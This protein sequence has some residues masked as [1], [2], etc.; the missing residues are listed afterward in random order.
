MT[1]ASEPQQPSVARSRLPDPH[2]TQSCG[3]LLC[4]GFRIRIAFAYE[5]TKW[6]PL[7]LL[8]QSPSA[9]LAAK[10]HTVD[11]WGSV[12]TTRM[13][14][15]RT[16]KRRERG[17]EGDSLA[18]IQPRRRPGPLEGGT[19]LARGRERNRKGVGAAAAGGTG[20]DSCGAGSLPRLP[21]QRIDHEAVPVRTPIQHCEFTHSDSA[22]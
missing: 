8:A 16:K 13:G 22:L 7:T 11:A 21:R 14:L 10:P 9:G 6:G 2:A 17:M 19:L 18:H 4:Q 1:H 20:R 15:E 3:R 12:H 5:P